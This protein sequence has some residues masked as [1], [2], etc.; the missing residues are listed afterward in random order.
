MATSPTLQNGA[1]LEQRRIEAGVNVSEL[2]EQTGLHPTYIRLLER[3][4]RSAQ[5]KTL[6]L[7]ADALGCKVKDVQR[8][9]AA[10][11]EAKRRVAA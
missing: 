5:P 7:I 9:R 4:K 11:A 1:E 8:P 10:S 3:E 6:K 2:A